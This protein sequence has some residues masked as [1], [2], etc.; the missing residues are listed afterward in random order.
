MGCNRIYRC[1]FF[2]VLPLAVIELK[3]IAILSYIWK[4]E[5]I[6]TY[7]AYAVRRI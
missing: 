3:K 1:L 2:F 7:G 4:T 5:T 6:V